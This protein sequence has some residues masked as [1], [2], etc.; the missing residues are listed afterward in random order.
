[1]TAA[2]ARVSELQR[3]I[4]RVV[5]GK[6]EVIQMALNAPADPCHSDRSQSASDHAV[7][8]PCVGP[9]PESSRVRQREAEV[10]SSITRAGLGLGALTAGAFLLWQY[11][12]NR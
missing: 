7:E 1:M 4:G 8:E 2:S 11:S 6:E 5:K 12:R 10:R 9:Y 3:S